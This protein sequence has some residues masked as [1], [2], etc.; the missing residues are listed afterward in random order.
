MGIP[1]QAPACRS[2]HAFPHALP[3]GFLIPFLQYASLRGPYVA[4]IPRRRCA[5]DRVSSRSLS[6]IHSSSDNHSHAHR[7]HK[8]LHM[9]GWVDVISNKAMQG[10]VKVGYSTKDPELRAEELNHTGTPHPY[11]VEYD[12]LIEEPRE[13]EQK[14]HHLLSS[15]REAKE[16]FRCSAEEAIAKIK[17]VSGTGAISESYPRAERAKAEALHQRELEAI[18]LKRKSEKEQKE[19]EDRF[20][21]EEATIRKQFDERIAASFPRRSF[22]VYWLWGGILVFIG[23]VNFKSLKMSDGG[24]VI[25]SVVFGALAGWCM[26]IYFE[27]KRTR[28]RSYIALEKQ[29]DEEL[30]EKT[31]E[32]FR[33]N[34]NKFWGNEVEIARCT[35]IVEGIVNGLVTTDDCRKIVLAT[36]A[37]TICN[38]PKQNVISM[39]MHPTNSY[40][41]TIT[42]MMAAN[43]YDALSKP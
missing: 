3:C 26:Q 4:P 12:M 14:T 1:K 9:K 22:W 10:L 34:L 15:K 11:V 27:S 13:I 8:G 5:V 37:K 39:L 43:I 32:I 31:N 2:T 17:Q 25:S 35:K 16:W 30:A 18:G 41:G 19:L 24:L 29:R 36:K 42:E 40:A 33:A 38:A 6:V 28:S 21:N 20:R 7:G 23:V